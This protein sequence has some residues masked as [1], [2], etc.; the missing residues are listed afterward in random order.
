MAER[1]TKAFLKSRL[2][3]Q[4]ST[5]FMLECLKNELLPVRNENDYCLSTCQLQS[6]VCRL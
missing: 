2:S 5:G 3:T 6:L 1:A 4:I